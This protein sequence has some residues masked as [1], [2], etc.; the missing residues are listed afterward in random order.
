MAEPQERLVSELLERAGV[1]MMTGACDTGKTSLARQV[2]AAAVDAG[3]TPAYVDA[4]VGQT[5]VGPPTC[6]GLRM[7]RQREDLDDLTGAHELRFVGSI[8]PNRFVLQ[9]V[10][11]TASLVDVARPE[12]DLIVI[13]TTGVVS[14]VSGQT[15]KYHKTELC[16]PSTVVALQRG[17]EMEP[18]VGMLRRFFSAEVRVT[19]VHPD[20]VPVS[21][22]QRAAHRAKRFAEALSAPL[23]RWRVRPTVF[24]PTLPA[25]LDHSRLDKMLVGVHDGAGRCLG[26]GVLSDEDENLRV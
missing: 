7:I 9:Q 10:V 13:D 17:G 11:A 15:L 23:E 26:L 1:V 22:E 4:D 24:A 3:M 2:L 25:G 14:G 20:V 18:I 16:R 6:V 21:P 12:A 8:S 19:G 5:T